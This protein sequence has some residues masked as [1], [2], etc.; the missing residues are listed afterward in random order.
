MGCEGEWNSKLLLSLYYT[1]LRE[2]SC[3]PSPWTFFSQSSESWPPPIFSLSLCAE[4]GI[5]KNNYIVT[6]LTSKIFA[7]SGSAA[8]DLLPVCGGELRPDGHEE[9]QARLRATHDRGWHSGSFHSVFV[10]PHHFGNPDPHPHQIK[11]RIRIKIFSLD[12]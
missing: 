10:D 5:N 3:V 6:F 2:R 9:G 4:S 12:P 11:I 7:F 8:T 1:W